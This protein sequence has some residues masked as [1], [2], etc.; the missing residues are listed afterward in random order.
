LNQ[1][2]PGFRFI[3]VVRNGLD[4]AFS[5][6]QNQVQQFSEWILSK[7]ER[8]LPGQFQALLFWGRVNELAADY[9]EKYL[10]RRYLRIAFEEICLQPELA[11]KRIHEFIGN[12][13]PFDLV[14]AIGE[15]QVP[16]TIGRWQDQ[17]VRIAHPMLL[18]GRPAL[19]RF[20]YWDQQAWEKLERVCR[21][22]LW[23]RWVRARQSARRCL[24]S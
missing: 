5:G 7:S 10:G 4:M 3:H 11:I 18:A 22:P 23:K 16:P 1:Q 2:F 6:N 24:A 13:D 9:G 19:E 15:I 12:L 8:A 14:A 20:G 17:P 21:V